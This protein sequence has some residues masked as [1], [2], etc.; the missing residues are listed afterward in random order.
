MNLQERKQVR[1]FARR[2]P[3]GRF[4]SC[5]VYIPR[6][7]YSANVVA[8]VEQVLLAAYG[9]VSAEHTTLISESVLARVHILIVLGRDAPAE[10]DAADVERKLSAVSRWWVDDLRDALVDAEGEHNGLTLL[11]RYGEAFPAFYRELNPPRAAVNDIRRL[12]AVEAGEN[13]ATALHRAS[14]GAPEDLRLKLATQGEPISLSAVLPLLEHLGMQVTDER[15]YELRLPD[16][17]RL[18]LYDFGLRAPAGASADTDEARDELRATFVGLWQGEIEGDGFNRLVLLAGLTGRQVA[19]LRAYAKY[20]RQIGAT[21]SQRYIEA[22]LASHPAI[23]GKLVRLFELR[24]DPRRQS[25][26]ALVSVDLADELRADLDAV[27]SLDE[28]R[29]LRSFLTLIEATVRTNAYRTGPDGRLRGWLSFK[30][31][32]QLVPDLPL[33]RPRHEIWVYAP[34]VEG[35]HLRGGAIARGGIRWSDRMEDFRTEVLGLMKAQMVKNAVIVPVGAKGGFVVKQASPDRSKL[36]QQVRDAYSTFIRG[37]LDVTDNIVE[38]EVVPPPQVVRR[39][40]DDPYLVVAADKGT[41]T[42]SDLA[43]SL[44][45][46]YGFWLGDA[47]ASGGSSGYDHKKMGITAK[48]A[49]ESVRRHFNGLGIDADTA[50]ITVVGIGDM[51][52]DVFG[53]GMLLS[54]SLRLVAAF[55]H[56]HRVPRPQPG[57]RGGLGRAPAAVRAARFVVGRL[58]PLEDLGRRRRVAA[59]GQEHRAEPRGP[60]RARHRRRL[61][62]PRWRCCR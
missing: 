4:V 30:L 46:E 53:N 33:P 61:R 25:E 16:G 41:A 45:A 59:S 7:R 13:L 2:D 6:D 15:P 8:K 18:W 31:D 32:P 11:A 54:H 23:A 60:R 14:G 48:G 38:G 37:M 51:S 9:G 19:V 5:L 34:R 58:R 24:F 56:R 1:L 29:I 17:V 44:A 62:S 28:D 40:G 12:A 49:W 57:R 20:L 50:P 47:F 27:A 21:F 22:T 55:D 3:A 52:G 36:T 39:D 43:N 26:P 42:F 10:V 35:V